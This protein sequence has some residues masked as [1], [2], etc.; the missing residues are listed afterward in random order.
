MLDDYYL[1]HEMGMLKPDHEAFEYV[2]SELGTP[3]ERIVF[4]DDQ[5]VNVAAAKQVGLDAFVTR[6]LGELEE[7]LVR[8]GVI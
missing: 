7:Q 8:L 2:I 6:G 1:S 5:E 3:A 4:F